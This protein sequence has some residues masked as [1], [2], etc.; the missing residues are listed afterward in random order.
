MPHCT[1][2]FIDGLAARLLCGAA[3]RCSGADCSRGYIDGGAVS[4]CAELTREVIEERG[5]RARGRSV[6]A[7]LGSCHTPLRKTRHIAAAEDSCNIQHTV[8]TAERRGNARQARTPVA[9]SVQPSRPS[10]QS[11]GSAVGRQLRY[12]PIEHPVVPPWVYSPTVTDSRQFTT[13]RKQNALC[14]P[15]RCELTNS[16]SIWLCVRVC[17]NCMPYHSRPTQSHRPP[18]LSASVA[19]Q[20]CNHSRNQRHRCDSER[21]AIGSRAS[22]VD[23]VDDASSAGMQRPAFRHAPA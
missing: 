15:R 21:E 23:A 6:R 16:H 5:V 18:R 9:H 13:A 17:R 8:G 11:C 3:Q 20:R 14:I 22:A 19:V 10:A 12:E 7:L 2:S 1:P 4:G